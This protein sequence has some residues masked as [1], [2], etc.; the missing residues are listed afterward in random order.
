MVESR[1]ASDPQDGRQTIHNDT[2]SE[3]DNDRAEV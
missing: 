2:G 3:G 1:D